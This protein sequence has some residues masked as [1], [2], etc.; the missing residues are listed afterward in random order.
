MFKK[1]FNEFKEFSIKGNMVDLAVGIII[2]TA[3][4]NVVNSLVNKVF[5]PPISLL[6]SDIKIPD[7]KIIL[8]QALRDG[9]TLIQDELA[10]EYG[11]VIQNLV[12]F[13]IIGMCAF[14]VVKIMNRLR[15]YNNNNDKLKEKPK[16]LPADIELL[17]DIKGVMEEQNQL[18]REIK[19]G[20]R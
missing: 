19:E 9:E 13:I 14:F 15:N 2:G 11:V 3:F 8:R 16:T 18:L 20:R 1:F 4:N 10:I 6:I 12:N 17:K 7:R 5:M